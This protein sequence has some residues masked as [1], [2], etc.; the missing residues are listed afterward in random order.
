MIV[1]ALSHA[2]QNYRRLDYFFLGILQFPH[3]FA[4]AG[5]PAPSGATVVS[6]DFLQPD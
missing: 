1:K 4:A 3:Q 5:L 6:A 2:R